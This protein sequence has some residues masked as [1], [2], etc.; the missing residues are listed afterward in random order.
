[1]GKYEKIENNESMIPLM[2]IQKIFTIKINIEKLCKQ[3]KK[4][5]NIVKR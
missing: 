3:L 4:L 2:D 5:K 1:M